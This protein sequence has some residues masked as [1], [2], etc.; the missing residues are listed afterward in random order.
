MNKQRR[1]VWFSCGIAS[2]S[3]CKIEL[4][5]GN[6]ITIA[7]CDTG[8]EHVDNSRFLK[9][10]EQLFGQKIISIKSG[11]YTDTW[12]VYN[13]TKYLVGI[14]GARCTTELKKKVRQK[15]QR[16]DDIHVFGYTA[17]ETSRAN[18]MVR[19]NPELLIKTPLIELGMTKKNCFDYFS[20]FGIKKPAMYRLGFN[21]NNCIGC[22]KGGMGYWNHIRKHFRDVFDRMALVERDLGVSCCKFQKTIEGRRVETPIFLD[23]LPPE[24]GSH[25]QMYAD[26]LFD[27][28]MSCDF[29]CGEST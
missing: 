24:R 9:D 1:V 22:P 20:Q 21:N 16:H 14:R 18:N 26:D 27:H 8:S 5:S 2:A 3:A 10:C 17:D 15:F 4:D 29:L 12:D 6:P 13:K 19:N 7:Y 23:E 25:K 28:G 11:K